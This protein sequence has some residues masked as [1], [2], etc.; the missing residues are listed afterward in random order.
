VADLSNRAAAA[1]F[2]VRGLIA[3][4]CGVSAFDDRADRAVGGFGGLR[5][6]AVREADPRGLPDRLLVL[7]V[8]FALALV[9]TGDASEQFAADLR[10][11]LLG[12][13]LF[14]DC[15]RRDRLAGAERAGG[16]R[17]DACL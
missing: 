13:V 14:G 4:S 8:G 17:D 2:V 7:G 6:L 5:D 3:R 9:R 10:A 15:D 1:R 12:A 16:R 11:G